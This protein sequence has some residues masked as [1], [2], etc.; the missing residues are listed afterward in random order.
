MDLHLRLDVSRNRH[1][2][3]SSP[4]SYREVRDSANLHLMSSVY[5]I[6]SKLADKFYIGSTSSSIEE[7]IL[8]HNTGFYE[9]SFTSQAQDW[10]LFIDLLCHD[11]THA[12]RVEKHI[13]KMKSKIYIL[14]LKK[15]PE[16]QFKLLEKLT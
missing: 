14:N 10:E 2:T 3:Y 11:M 13:K 15:Y 9:N 8:K 12:K 4:D 1:W 7:R 16:M 6:H 5:I